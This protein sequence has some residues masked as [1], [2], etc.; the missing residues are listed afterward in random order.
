MGRYRPKFRITIEQTHWY[1]WLTS[2][3][4]RTKTK[5]A[6]TAWIFL[7]FFLDSDAVGNFTK[8]DGQMALVI[9]I[10][11]LIVL[12]GG[13]VAFLL[14]VYVQKNCIETRRHNKKSGQ[15]MV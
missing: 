10:A 3:K 1:Y 14:V 9:L 2:Q 5:R 11:A 8:I 15:N 7:H 4:A 6:A 13:T 12:V